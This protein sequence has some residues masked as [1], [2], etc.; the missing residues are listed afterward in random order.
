MVYFYFLKDGT[1]RLYYS[2]KCS[3]KPWPLMYTTVAGNYKLRY[4]TL[5]QFSRKQRLLCRHRPSGLMS[6]GWA[7]RM[8][9]SHL[10]HPCKQVTEAKSKAQPTHGWLW[11]HW[12]FHFPSAMWPCFNSLSFISLLCH[13]FLLFC[14]QNIV[15]LFLFCT[16]SFL[17]HNNHKALKMWRE[18][19]DWPQSMSDDMVKIFWIFIVVVCLVFASSIRIRVMEKLTT[20]TA[21]GKTTKY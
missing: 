10:I 18:R 9:G 5:R 8:K 1:W 2:S 7:P 21:W 4:G 11:L 17:L 12:L 6:K 20:Q 16:P 14:V 19:A 13:P 3:Q 15:C